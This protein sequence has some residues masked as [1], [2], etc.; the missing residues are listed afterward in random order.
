MGK[1]ISGILILVL[2]AGCYSTVP[3]TGRKVEF[4]ASSSQVAKVAKL[5]SDEILSNHKIFN[6]YN[7]QLILK[8]MQPIASD[9]LNDF[10]GGW[11]DW[12]FILIQDNKPDIYCLE[13]G[14]I[15]LTSGLF[16]ILKHDAD[17]MLLVGHA[18][19]HKYS[20]HY[21]ERLYDVPINIQ[22]NKLPI[23]LK[24]YLGLQDDKIYPFT[25]FHEKE[26]D[27]LSMRFL[28][29]SGYTPIAGVSFW[30]SI[31]KKIHRLAYKYVGSKYSNE[32]YDSIDNKKFY[33]EV[34]KQIKFYTPFFFKKH[35]ITK[36]RIKALTESLQ[37]TLKLYKSQENKKNLGT[38]YTGIPKSILVRKRNIVTK[39]PV[40]TKETITL[41]PSKEM[42]KN[43]IKKI[44]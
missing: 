26:A 30:E 11:N 36:K 9:A 4:K 8:R 33:K 31:D 34:D 1:L 14:K 37:D 29:N 2:I 27:Y 6:D 19:A 16:S 23:E 21:D 40:Y 38:I 5:A 42:P 28:A 22:E 24:R 7:C 41:D 32:S 39:K 44:K 18:V 17:F 15:I 25:T 35:K 12:E 13:K 43:M 3:I 10:F 20:Y